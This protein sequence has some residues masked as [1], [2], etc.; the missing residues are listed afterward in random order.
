MG[1][2]VVVVVVVV[3]VMVVLLLLLRAM[4]YASVSASSSAIAAPW[5]AC[6]VMACAASPMSTTRASG[7]VQ[8]GSGGAL[9]SLLQAAV[10]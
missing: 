5:P 10:Y 1:V 3:I 4:V 8:L 9:K 2:V 7:N 6:G